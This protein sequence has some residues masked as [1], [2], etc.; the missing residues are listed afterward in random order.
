MVT[1]RKI[2]IA[3]RDCPCRCGWPRRYLARLVV[4][5]RGKTQQRL[6]SLCEFHG[7]VFAARHGMELPA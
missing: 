2:E 5:A 7:A 1:E 6:L 3:A 4:Q